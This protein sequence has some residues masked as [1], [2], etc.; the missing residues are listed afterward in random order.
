MLFQRLRCAPADFAAVSTRIADICIRILYSIE[1]GVVLVCNRL[2]DSALHWKSLH[3]QLYEYMQHVLPLE[4]LWI[5]QPQGSD[6]NLR[7]IVDTQRDLRP[8]TV[9][10]IRILNTAVTTTRPIPIRG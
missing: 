10:V 1:I 9:H 4:S 7:M 8:S 5:A 2:V 3:V 6:T